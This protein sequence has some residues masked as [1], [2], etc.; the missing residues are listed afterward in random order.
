MLQVIK[1]LNIIKAEA[2]I[3]WNLHKKRCLYN[4]SHN[5]DF[6]S[7]TCDNDLFPLVVKG[8]SNCNICQKVI[9]RHF[10]P[11]IHAWCL[12]PTFLSILCGPNLLMCLTRLTFVSHLQVES[13]WT[14]SPTLPLSPGT[15]SSRRG[16]KTRLERPPT[17]RRSGGGP[18]RLP[19]PCGQPRNTAGNSE[20]WATSSTAC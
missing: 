9:I 16:V 4:N 14:Q 13:G 17:E 18:S 5:Q 12:F 8:Y 3:C 15:W 10:L 2:E 7:F 19:L 20:G 1:I 6:N 11:V